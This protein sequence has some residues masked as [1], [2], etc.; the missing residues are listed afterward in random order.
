MA[1]LCLAGLQVQK[2]STSVNWQQQLR[3]RVFSPCFLI[4]TSIDAASMWLI[5][6]TNY[7]LKHRWQT[8]VFTFLSTFVPLVGIV[9]IMIAAL[10]TLRKG[11]VEGMLLTLLATLPYF[12]SIYAPSS[13]H[14]VLLWVTISVVVLSN[15]LTCVFAVMLRRKMSL[16]MVMQ[17]AA[18]AAVLVISVVHLMYPDVGDW[19]SKEL[20]T[21][22]SEATTMSGI[23]KAAVPAL[24]MKTQ[25]EMIH[26]AKHYVT[27]LMAAA[28]LLNA[29]LQLIMA[30]WWES[31]VFNSGKLRQELYHLRLTPLA[32][33]LFVASLLF[34]FLGNSVVL[35]IM[36]VLVVLF[37][38]SGLSL[39]H[40]F[41][42]MTGGSGWI[43]LVV[44]YVSLIWAF[45]V[46]VIFVGVLALLD[47][48]VDIRKRVKK[49]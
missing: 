31:V 39:V 32:G 21:Y 38:A 43:W 17:V 40:Y 25:L 15:A 44:F 11:V 14:V 29:F 42:G 2:Q 26:I 41:F 1:K 6:F 45:P 49:V 13:P 19:W 27:G 4:A 22:Y 36:P 28:I 23:T 37:G 30:R 7:L 9:G 24:P 12:I 5:R 33:T 3:E 35:D 20:Q 48:W 16:A 10:V 46:S 8:A 47:I 18:L 34:S